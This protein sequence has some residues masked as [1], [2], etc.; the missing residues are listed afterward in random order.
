MKKLFNIYSLGATVTLAAVGA[1]IFFDFPWLQDT[2]KD[3]LPDILEKW[4]YKTDPFKGDSDGDLLGDGFEVKGGLDPL[5]AT[6]IN[7]DPDQDGLDNLTEAIYG[8]D[9]NNRDTDGDGTH[10]GVEVNQGSLPTDDD[11]HGNKP[12]ATD[13]VKVQLSVGDSSGSHSER[14][15]LVVGPIRHQAPDFGRVAT[16]TYTFKKGVT[17][18][19]SLVHTGTL[20]EKLIEYGAPDFDWT[21]SIR[22][23]STPVGFF[24]IDDERQRILGG[25]NFDPKPDLVFPAANSKAT[26]Y[27]PLVDIDGDT[28]SDGG[29]DEDDEVSGIGNNQVTLN[30]YQSE[31][32]EQSTP[33]ILRNIQPASL[34]EGE[35]FLK[36]NGE[37]SVSIISD[38]SDDAFVLEGTET[39]SANLWVKLQ[40][41]DLELVVK[42]IDAGSVV[43]DLVYQ[44][45]GNV[46]SKD[47][48]RILATSSEYCSDI[49]DE[50][51]NRYEFSLSGFNDK[52]GIAIGDSPVLEVI[53][54]CTFPGK[55]FSVS[56]ELGDY[57]VT[58]PVFLTDEVTGEWVRQSVVDNYEGPHYYRSKPINIIHN[59][60]AP[61]V[62]SMIV[63]ANQTSMKIKFDG[64][65]HLEAL[66][67]IDDYVEN[68]KQT[69]NFIDNIFQLTRFFLFLDLTDSTELY[70][71]AKVALEAA[72]AT[73]NHPVIFELFL[74][75]LRAITNSSLNNQLRDLLDE[76]SEQMISEGWWDDDDLET[77]DAKRA[78]SLLKRAALANTLNRLT[79]LNR[80]KKG[81][82]KVA[83]N[84]Y[85]NYAPAEALKLLG[86]MD[87]DDDS[88]EFTQTN[89]VANT[90]EL[91]DG[92]MEKIYQHAKRE[93]TK[94]QEIWVVMEK[95]REQFNWAQQQTELVFDWSSTRAKYLNQYYQAERE[96]KKILGDYQILAAVVGDMP[97]WM[98]IINERDKSAGLRSIQQAV[99]VS[100]DNVRN[101]INEI[102]EMRDVDDL[103]QLGGPQYSH[104]HSIAASMDA[105]VA[106]SLVAFAKGQYVHHVNEKY[107][108]NAVF[109][110]ATFIAYGVGFVFP[111]AAYMAGVV[112]VS[113]S[114][115]KTITAY[116]E[117]NSAEIS[118]GAG[119]GGT[120]EADKAKIRYHNALGQ[121]AF[122]AAFAYGDVMAL[123]RYQWRKVRSG[124]EMETITAMR[125]KEGFKKIAE[126]D[127]EYFKNLQKQE[128]LVNDH[129][130]KAAKKERQI[131]D[132]EKSIANLSRKKHDRI[133]A[134]IVAKRDDAKRLIG[135]HLGNKQK[136]LTK[137]KELNNKHAKNPVA[138][139][140]EK[141]KEY[142]KN[143]ALFEGR[144]NKQRHRL[145]EVESDLLY[146][147][148]KRFNDDLDKLKKKKQKEQDTLNRHKKNIISSKA[149]LGRLNKT[150]VYSGLDE[151]NK[152]H[153]LKEAREGAHVQRKVD[154]KLDRVFDLDYVF[155][156]AKRTKRN[157]DS[158]Y[159]NVYKLGNGHYMFGPKVKG[160][161]GKDRFVSF[162]VDGKKFTR[163]KLQYEIKTN[164]RIRDKNGAYVKP[165]EKINIPG[166]G[167]IKTGYKSSSE[168]MEYDRII[169]DHDA[170][171]IFVE[172]LVRTANKKHL[173]KTW[174]YAKVL[175]DVT[176]YN[177]TNIP[178][179]N[180]ISWPRDIVYSEKEHLVDILKPD[181][182]AFPGL[183]GKKIH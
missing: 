25:Y 107:L 70:Q 65:R 165:P 91:V 144:A 62:D 146:T 97:A 139:Y 75:D 54:N 38:S 8:S 99:A 64:I 113:R 122:D 7:A 10:D 92:Y 149:R 35:I 84:N 150:R 57:Q 13:V 172:D 90:D 137:I 105:P 5:A 44:R 82:G 77:R 32:Y 155:A 123:K 166:K 67:L 115:G 61:L 103:V 98:I 154:Q 21:A 158:F 14:Y 52:Y 2:D 3:G 182:E 37:G 111:P 59:T 56:I 101:L 80:L 95:R 118:S 51:K 152:T 47:S 156:D 24:V 55:T 109:D 36:K 124:P 157:N 40:Q 171:I 159:Q 53:A 183:A 11:D 164:T 63:A 26:L 142:N 126:S 19:V 9:P 48:L 140:Q 30:L 145:A 87:N 93:G 31:G 153:R 117:A 68:A 50:D 173:N 127:A 129:I 170:R 60:E 88:E 133:Y 100:E 102:V 66:S 42:A 33:I 28:N 96:Y 20:P 78:W 125:S 4:V 175:E 136:N 121:L 120:L 167:E 45:S 94:L 15:N 168:Y 73:A 162:M 135:K 83:G 58:V 114:G 39:S 174:T 22:A 116:S 71:Y 69:A 41:N 17:H 23:T 151:L 141:L 110:S 179:K 34:P 130:A 18:P 176:G 46:V 104:L 72:Q 79:E 177:A 138:N 16:N 106:K 180:N 81:N 74:G 161:S 128:G 12:A 49:I 178:M 6:D 76:S 119:L 86:E 29:V 134:G 85:L 1:F 148:E 108:L 112:D 143:V 147:A 160:L 181:L 89:G 132:T 43:L 27:I 163:P 169:M 131:I